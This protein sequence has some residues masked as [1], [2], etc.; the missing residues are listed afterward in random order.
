MPLNPVEQL[1]YND[2][3]TMIRADAPFSPHR[4]SYYIPLVRARVCVALNQDIDAGVIKD[5]K[6]NRTPKVDEYYHI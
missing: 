5:I 1:Q 2:L 3:K 4:A 6:V